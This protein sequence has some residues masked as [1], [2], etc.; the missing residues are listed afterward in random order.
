[1]SSDYVTEILKRFG[2][3]SQ[4]GVS[5]IA[6]ILALALLSAF[7]L[8]AI[9]LLAGSS[10]VTESL[11]MGQQAF[12]IA[13]AGLTVNANKLQQNWSG[14]NNP[15]N[16]PNLNFAGGVIS[17]SI[18]DDN[19]GDGDPNQDSNGRLIMTSTGTLGDYRRSIQATIT[20]T[21][22][23]LDAAVYTTADLT[24]G[25]NATVVGE[26]VE[27]SLSLPT[28]DEAAAIQLAKENKLNGYATRPNGNYFRGHFPIG[29]KPQSLNGV[30]YVDTYP[31]GMPASVDLSDLKTTDGKPA[32]LVV[33]GRLKIREN[34]FFN[35]VIYNA[36]GTIFDTSVAGNSV[37][38]GGLISS[39]DVSITG[40]ASIVYDASM[41]KTDITKSLITDI[42]GNYIYDWQELD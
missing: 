21:V 15:S 36:G 22:P 42:R 14:W 24:I 17:V 39:H 33:M 28:L 31:Y 29:K 12:Y 10:S 9:W 35:G 26:T 4:R 38:T 25:R 16:F 20:R 13:E 37:I 7:S 23:A 2:R 40:T 8:L 6:L 30:I 5:I 32:L 11:W 41:T 19:D 1:M 27:N 34:V 3:R 18:K